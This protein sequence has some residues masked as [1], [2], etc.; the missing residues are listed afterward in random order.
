M[1]NPT[2]DD[3]H[4][5]ARILE[6][7]PA[8]ELLESRRVERKHQVPSKDLTSEGPFAFRAIEKIEFMAYQKKG[9]V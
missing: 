3:Q 5:I 2:K 1:P 6:S 9:A 4:E 7:S 8:R